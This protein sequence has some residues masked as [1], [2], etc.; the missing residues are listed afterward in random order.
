MN[1]KLLFDK[2][3]MRQLGY[4]AVD[5]VI[6]HIEH[7]P[8]KNATKQKTRTELEAIFRE[9][10]PKDGMDPMK[11]LN[12]VEKEVFAN[13][14]HI[15][16]PR[17]FAFVPGPSNYMGA[18]ADF[19]TA[20]FNVIS[21]DW[22]EA[23]AAAQIELVVIKW[24]TDMFKLPPSAGGVFVSGG[25]M[26][27][28]MA[29]ILSIHHKKQEGKIGIIYC[30]DQTHSSIE[31]AVTILGKE[32]VELRKI[33]SDA[34]FKI[35]IETLN[36][37]IQV[38][39]SNNKQPLAIVA[40]AGTT[41]TGSVDNLTR[42]ADI[43]EQED[44]WFHVDGAYG[45]V[46]I[47]DER[48]KHLYDG[49]DRIDSMTINP[50]KWLFQPIEAACFLVREQHK[51]KDVFYIM[52]EYLKDIDLSD[53]EINYGNYGIQLTRSF[54]AFKL[55][56]SL[57]AFGLNSFG[58]AIKTGINLVELAEKE[59]KKYA[60]WVVVAPAKLGIINFQY[61]P[62]NQSIAQ[63]NQL[64]KAVIEAI[65]KTGFAMISSTVLK[66][67]LVIRLCIINPRTTEGDI[68]ETIRRLNQIAI[69]LEVRSQTE[70]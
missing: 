43:C 47:L 70:K 8:E 41:N 48:Q 40:T 67:H 10:M 12:L 38:D 62:L 14:M 33:Q 26:A 20:G 2:E 7:L 18:L 32:R 50:H 21:C 24:L 28:L 11:L 61:R 58:A 4:R 59:I 16:H 49:I 3:T 56:M 31:R 25:S 39:K 45:A 23:S 37:Q 35:E 6:N 64:N 57:K 30:S 42:I 1:P 60:N 27:N 29:L 36:K 5:M 66:E 63:T 53:E 46:A 13:I 54:K 44:L 34:T 9:E 17:F 19:L 51:L 65:V 68:K 52:P 69:H 15:D 22:L 55:W